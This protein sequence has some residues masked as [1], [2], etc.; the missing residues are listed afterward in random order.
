MN[1]KKVINTVTTLGSHFDSLDEMDQF[2]EERNLPKVTQD[3]TE[4]LNKPI[5]IKHIKSIINNLQK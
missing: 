1:I 2:L 3:K 5:S 4:K